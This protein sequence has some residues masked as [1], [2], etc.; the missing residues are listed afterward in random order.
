MARADRLA[1]AHEFVLRYE[2]DIYRQTG[3][4]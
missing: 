1:Q 4:T 2:A 3:E